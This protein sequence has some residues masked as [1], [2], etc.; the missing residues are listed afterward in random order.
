MRIHTYTHVGRA[1]FVRTP[2]A[3]TNSQ[4][5]NPTHILP[6]N[7]VLTS[8]YQSF[9]PQIALGSFEDQP[10]WLQ[11]QI[12]LSPAGYWH[13]VKNRGRVCN[14][15]IRYKLPRWKVLLHVHNHLTDVI[16]PRTT[17]RGVALEIIHLC[18]SLNHKGAT[19]LLN[20]INTND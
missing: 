13:R 1:I 19:C 11:F 12:T 2:I 3:I 8:K 18:T 9:N 14:L 7:P 17:S 16:L 20:C 6:L 10:T 15:R 4:A 5:L